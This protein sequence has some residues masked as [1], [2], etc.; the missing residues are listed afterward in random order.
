MLNKR[1]GGD[2]QRA[3][4]RYALLAFLEQLGDAYAR[5]YCDIL[6]LKPRTLGLARRTA[7]LLRG[8][9]ELFYAFNLKKAGELKAERDRIR[10]AID[11]TLPRSVGKDDIIALQ[12]LRRIADLII[13][14]EKFQLAMQV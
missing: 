10:D 2:V 13:D 4:H 11:A 12:H 6:K 5:L 3:M 7:K 14:I 1:G 9:Y 8:F